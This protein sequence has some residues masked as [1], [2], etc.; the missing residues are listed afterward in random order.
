MGERRSGIPRTAF[1]LGHAWQVLLFRF[2]H[3]GIESDFMVTLV[4]E[5]MSHV[6]N[7]HFPLFRNILERRVRERERGGIVT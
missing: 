4:N 3:A 1:A 5:Q 7:L 2:L 6:I